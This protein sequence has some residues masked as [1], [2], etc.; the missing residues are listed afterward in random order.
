MNRL[1]TATLLGF[2]VFSASTAFS[3]ASKVYVSPQKGDDANACTLSSPCRQFTT[4]LTV[5]N[6]GG[7]IIVLDSGAFSPFTVSIGVSIIAEGVVADVISS[8]DGI[9]ITANDD[10]TLRGLTI[11]GTGIEAF[12]GIK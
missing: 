12:S 2:F 1:R 8:S 4:A 7:V 6:S 9:V 3:A 5:V 11:T 10:V